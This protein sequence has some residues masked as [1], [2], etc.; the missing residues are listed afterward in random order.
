MW[1]NFSG[2]IVMSML[3]INEQG[4][5]G[6]TAWQGCRQILVRL[7]RRSILSISNPVQQKH[8]AGATIEVVLDGISHGK[9][10]LTMHAAE[11]TWIHVEAWS[12]REGSRLVNLVIA[13]KMCCNGFAAKLF[14]V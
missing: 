1:Q 4:L 6:D 13:A 3:Q 10:S 7:D 12:E 14:K 9:A 2:R 8:R 5:M 11:P